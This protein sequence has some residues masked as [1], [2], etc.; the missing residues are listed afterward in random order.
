[1]ES[2]LD[3]SELAFD[4]TVFSGI[5]AAGVVPVGA[6]A[7]TVSAVTIRLLRRAGGLVDGLTDFPERV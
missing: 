7:S 1:M 5:G 4:R 2:T 6:A 3:F